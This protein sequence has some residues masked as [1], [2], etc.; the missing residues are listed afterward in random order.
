MSVRT[1]WI[2]VA[3]SAPVAGATAVFIVCQL[4][5]IFGRLAL[6]VALSVL[7]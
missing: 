5:I 3:D 6:M 1:P 4:G 7:Y 2:G